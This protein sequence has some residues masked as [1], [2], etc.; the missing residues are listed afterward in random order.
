MKAFTR[1]LIA[2]VGAAAFASCT[3]NGNLIYLNIQKTTKTTTSSN[4]PLN[5]T[6]ADMVNVTNSSFPGNASAPYYA[7]AG[8]IYNG[9]VS[10]GS[11]NW[12]AISTPNNMVCNT[13]TYDGDYNQ[14]WAGFFSP[15]GSTFGLYWST[16]GSNTWNLVTDTL[17]PNYQ[18]TYVGVPSTASGSSNLGDLF[19]VVEWMSNGSPVYELDTAQTQNGAPPINWTSTGLTSSTSPITGV[20]FVGTTNTYF[21][22]SGNTLYTSSGTFPNITFAAVSSSTFPAGSNDLL[23][24]IYVDPSY[25]G[26]TFIAV[27][28]S[29]QTTQTAGVGG[30]FYSTNGGTS[31]SEAQSN[32]GTSYNAGFLCVAGPVDAG[33]TTYLAGADSG[34]GG[35]FGFFYF[36]PSSINLQRFEGISYSLYAS[37]VRR[38]IVDIPNNII[39]MGTINNGLWVT[40]GGTGSSWSGNIDG[41]TWTQE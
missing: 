41:N 11:T 18:I 20:G 17:H 34:Y 32:A 8:K 23:Q 13:L 26:G 2:A 15:N 10:N 9:T 36:T 25:S 31:W 33:H 40:T 14:L 1:L 6:I 35:S 16:P 28:S 22:V 4:I 38:I 24:G 27:P 30:I 19:V 21:A 12:S 39:A 3:A 7:A 5:I 37:A 29:N